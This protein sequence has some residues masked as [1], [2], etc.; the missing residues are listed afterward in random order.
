MTTVTVT[1]E[2]ILLTQETVETITVTTV[3][4]GPPG[5]Q[6]ES[7]FT[8]GIDVISGGAS[9]TDYSAGYVFDGGAA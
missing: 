2:V 3:E 1:E 5:I 8:V 6:G 4:Q 9:N 7:G